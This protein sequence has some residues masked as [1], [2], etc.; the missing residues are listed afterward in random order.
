MKCSK[1]NKELNENTAQWRA[2]LCPVCADDQLAENAMFLLSEREK[3][4]ALSDRELSDLVIKK[5]WGQKVGWCSAE[6]W[7]L[8]E[9]IQ[10]F[11]KAKGIVR[12]E[13]E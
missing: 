10:R 11:D 5:I 13:V 8:D 2:D 4:E 7:I 3:V 6:D 1:C 12:E 9:F